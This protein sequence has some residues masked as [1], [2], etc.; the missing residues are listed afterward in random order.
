[1]TLEKTQLERVT[2]QC[3]SPFFSFHSFATHDGVKAGS[4]ESDETHPK[5]INR[6]PWFED[7]PGRIPD[8]NKS[9]HDQVY[10]DTDDSTTADPQDI[11]STHM[12]TPDQHSDVEAIQQ[13]G[14]N[15]A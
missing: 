2:N 10:D 9:N 8:P 4:T 6:A 1:M 12:T 14:R 3:F 13:H 11:D 7:P 15:Y 5:V